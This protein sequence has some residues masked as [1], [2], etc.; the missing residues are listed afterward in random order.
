MGVIKRGI[1]GGFS[2]KVANVIGGSWKG[3]AYMRSQPLSVA[4]PRTTGQV[5]QRDRFSFT[6]VFASV[7]LAT[8]IKPL[9]DR[10]AVQMSGYNHFVS[11]NSKLMLDWGTTV[12]ANVVMS[13]GK[14][15]SSVFTIGMVSVGD[16]DVSLNW[17]ND[18]VT[19]FK[20]ETDLAYVVIANENGEWVEAFSAVTPRSDDSVIVTITKPIEIGQ[21]LHIY[22]SFLRADGTIVSD[23]EYGTI[24]ITA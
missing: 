6:A 1:L 10:F 8:W 16:G 23:S 17:L 19:G 20:L 3:I 5:A 12:W 18:P 24:N 9:W 21:T 13:T 4:N 15:E 22:L 14:M 11:I 7:I 2:G